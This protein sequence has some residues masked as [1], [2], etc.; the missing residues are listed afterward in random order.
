MSQGLP[1][2]P[3]PALEPVTEG[4][5]RA[6]GRG[7]LVVQRCTACREH[8]HPPT[9]VCHACGSLDWTWD[10]VAGTGRVFSYTWT[11]APVVP[12]LA[13]LGAYNVTVV[14]LDGTQGHVRLLTRII[15]VERDDLVVGL[16]VTVAFD[17]IDDEVALP[18]FRPAAGEEAP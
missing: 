14:E 7:Q 12:A 9:E 13:D 11:D 8:R 2:L 15:D 18:V 6:A 17:P 4:Y 16:P 3:R 5:W 10:E 1:G